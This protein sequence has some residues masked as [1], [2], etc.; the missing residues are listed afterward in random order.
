MADRSERRKYARLEIMSNVTFRLME[1]PQE[2][3]PADRFRGIG[4]N[5]GA[6]GL[7]F[8]SDKELEQ[9]TRLEMEIFLPG[10]EAPVYITGSVRWCRASVMD[11]KKGFDTGVKFDTINRNHVLMLIKYVCGNLSVDE[12]SRLDG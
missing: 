5:I 12:I 9:E 4:K 7:L 3:E 1:T 11:G 10:K 6:E 2:N 8:F